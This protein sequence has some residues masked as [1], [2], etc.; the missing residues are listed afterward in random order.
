M[1]LLFS[2]VR[3]VDEMSALGVVSEVL[4]YVTLW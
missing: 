4:W 3:Q 1:H 2:Y